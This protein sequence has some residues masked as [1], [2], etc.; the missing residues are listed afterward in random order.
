MCQSLSWESRFLEKPWW[1]SPRF[2]VAFLRMR[3]SVWVPG[4]RFLEVIQ[5]MVAKS[6]T[7]KRMV[8]TWNHRTNGI[9]RIN[10]LSTG[11]GFRNHP[12]MLSDKAKAR[13]GDG[14]IRDPQMVGIG[15]H[16][17]VRSWGTRPKREQDAFCAS[18]SCR[19]WTIP[20]M[21]TQLKKGLTPKSWDWTVPLGCF[22]GG[23]EPTIP[24][25]TIMTNK[26][27]QHYKA[28]ICLQGPVPGQS[29]GPG[30]GN[31]KWLNFLEDDFHQTFWMTWKKWR[32]LFF[33]NIG[34]TT[35]H[36]FFT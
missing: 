33:P 19:F 17:G 13:N 14:K 29:H 21:K 35:K 5:W 20:I 32:N 28:E 18:G 7:T 11:A 2:W 23:T 10:P 24:M 3:S 34:N 16:V 22:P 1:I 8:E 25:R 31:G 9:N 26:Y 36:Y 27:N 30:T 12:Q 15:S 4:L 6:C